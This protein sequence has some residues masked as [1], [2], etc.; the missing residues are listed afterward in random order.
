MEV[1]SLD[2][3]CQPDSLYKYSSFGQ[4]YNSVQTIFN[5]LD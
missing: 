5:I 2:L 4:K 1:I 3:F